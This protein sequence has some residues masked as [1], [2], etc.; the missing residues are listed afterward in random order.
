[1][2]EPR[3]RIPGPDLWTAVFTGILAV[4]AVVALVVGY[5]QLKEFH[6]EAQV[7]HLLALQQQMEQEPMLTYRRGL[8]AKRL[9]N[10]EDPDELYPVLDFFETVGLLVRRGYLD[11]ADVWNTFSYP[12]F[13]LNADARQ[14]I[15]Q[16]QRQDP[17]T[18]A[19]FTSL[20]ERL[21]RIEVENHGT[22][23]HPS[24]EEI[25]TYWKQE[26]LAGRSVPML[27]HPR[28]KTTK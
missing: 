25:V 24:K 4:T 26:L 27:P 5:R 20:V 10:E 16:Q 1:M 19:D 21:Q 9:N 8:A 2:T 28:K 14:I 23:A 15:E 3:Q 6:A 17:T 22:I 11:E 7:Q 13:V 12:V 18:H